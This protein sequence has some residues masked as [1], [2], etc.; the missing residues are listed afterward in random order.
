MNSSDRRLELYD[1][2]LINSGKVEFRRIWGNR[3]LE[4][5][6]RRSGKQTRTIVSGNPAAVVDSASVTASVDSV[7]TKGSA[8]WLELHE[9]LKK[10][11]PLTD[12]KFAESQR[13]KE[14]A[15]F[16]LGKIYRF[17]LKEQD[18]AIVTF[19]RVLADFPKTQHKD[20]IYY[21]IYLTLADDDN[22]RTAWKDKL[23]TEFPNST[24][25]RLISKR[26]DKDGNASGTGNPVKEYE[27]TYQLY[28]DGNYEKALEEIEANL[29]SYKGGVMEDKFALLR[30]F[31]I[32]KVRGKEAYSQAINEFIQLYPSSEYLP[33]LKEMKELSA[34]S[35][36]K[37]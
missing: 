13:N 8:K 36:E 34:L 19:N 2:A 12:E 20:E 22:N 24:Y 31:L 29:P 21:L 1:P 32:G 35:V 23:L 25:A 5:D 30:V 6:W 10:D 27:S 16:K 11:V 37:R 18:K 28:V 17:D 33:R 3:V 15:L 7:M 9:A 14:E 26:S 4:D